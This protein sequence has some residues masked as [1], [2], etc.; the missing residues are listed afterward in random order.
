MLPLEPPSWELA[1]EAAAAVRR[2][3]PD[4]A[5]RRGVHATP[6]ALTGFV[7]RSVHHLL[8]ERLGLAAG[9]ACSSVRLLDPAAGPANFIME[10]WRVAIAAHRLRAGEDGGAALLRDHLLPHSLGIELLP[11]PV[12]L[13]R[14]AVRRFLA[15]HGLKAGHGRPWALRQADALAVPPPLAPGPGT[16]A[17]VLGNP[18][19][20]GGRAAPGWASGLVAAWRTRRRAG[21]EPVR[22]RGSGSR[23]RPGSPAGCPRRVAGRG[24]PGVRSLGLAGAE[25]RG[26]GRLGRRHARLG[27]GAARVARVPVARRAVDRPGLP[28]RAAAAGPLPAA[29]DRHRHRRRRR[30]HR[31]GPRSR[32]GTAGGAAAGGPLAPARRPHALS[33]A[34]VRPAP[35]DLFAAAAGAAEDGDRGGPPPRR[36]GPA[37]HPRRCR[38]AG[39]LRHPL[40]RRAQGREPVRGQRG[41]PAPPAAGRCQPKDRSG[42][43]PPGARR[44]SGAPLQ[45]PPGTARPLRLRLRAAPHPGLPLPAP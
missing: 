29:L 3:D 36:P 9:L 43:P 30:A 25:A 10:A 19:F 41:L 26:P 24:G 21:R 18:P 8:Q 38:R 42:Q 20:T 33:G 16:V 7:V 23:R 15:A 4:L 17:V 2:A 5:R 14:L 31:P 32:R 44:R 35:P 22:G 40:A 13:G 45:Q 6:P 37:R 39:G 34:A 11:Q 27:G 1:E 28:L 12:A